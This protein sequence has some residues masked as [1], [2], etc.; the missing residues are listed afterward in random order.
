[1]GIIPAV[2]T[3]VII[4]YVGLGILFILLGIPM[5]AGRVKPNGLYGF[6]TPK[7]FSSEPI[8]YAANRFAGKEIIRAGRTIVVCSTIFLLVNVVGR[9]S[10]DFVAGFGLLIA[11]MP[12]CIAVV[13]SFLYLRTL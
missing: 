12:L 8:W 7:T 3:L 5:Y 2:T 10:M 9:F 11:I 1:M 4:S 6:R 13:K